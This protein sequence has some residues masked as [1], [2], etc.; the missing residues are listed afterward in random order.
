MTTID[1]CSLRR[2]K[3]SSRDWNKEEKRSE[4]K[5]RSKTTEKIEK[6][7][8]VDEPRHHGSIPTTGTSDRPAI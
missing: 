6:E 7:S 1:S 8:E 4:T 5:N 3:R 2:G